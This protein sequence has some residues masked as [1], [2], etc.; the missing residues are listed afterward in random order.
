MIQA[1]CVNCASF[2]NY[3]DNIC[4]YK[5]QFLLKIAMCYM[6]VVWWMIEAIASLYFVK[7]LFTMF[8]NIQSILD[9]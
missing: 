3:I 2:E 9:K 8:V 7:F 6:K 4:M 1:H 5:L